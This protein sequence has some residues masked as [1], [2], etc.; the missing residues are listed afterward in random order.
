MPLLKTS[1]LNLTTNAIVCWFL[2][3]T[4]CEPKIVLKIITKI[5]GS[6]Q[7]STNNWSSSF[8][9]LKDT[10][11][12]LVLIQLLKFL[13]IE[14]EFLHEKIISAFLVLSKL[15][16]MCF[17]RVL[18]DVESRDLSQ[19]DKSII[20]VSSFP[21]FNFWMINYSYTQKKQFSLFWS[22]LSFKNF[23]A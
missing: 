21:S 4:W 14:F 5:L 2:C 19:A 3:F 8:G 6:K 9:L 16:H 7:K 12:Y 10:W 1:C 20:R 13:I 15:L 18:L 11:S 17:D 22:I 23:Q